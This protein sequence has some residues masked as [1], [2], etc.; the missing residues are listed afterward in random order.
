MSNLLSQAKPKSNKLSFRPNVLDLVLIALLLVGAVWLY[1][2]SSIGVNYNWRWADAFELVF[3]P[4]AD[5]SY[6]TSS[7]DLSQRFVLACG[8]CF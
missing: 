1:H 2:R 6:P 5:G 7:K 4:R 3:T 8:A